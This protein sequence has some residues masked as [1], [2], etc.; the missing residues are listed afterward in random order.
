MSKI[1]DHVIRIDSSKV[2][3]HIAARLIANYV[4]CGG[5]G[6]WLAWI[7]PLWDSPIFDCYW[8]SETDATGNLASFSLV[9][10]MLRR[11]PIEQLAAFHPYPV[12]RLLQRHTSREQ[13]QIYQLLRIE[14]GYTIKLPDIC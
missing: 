2:R 6:K 12:L 3:V 9:E 5:H 13:F 8:K 14:Y 4:S 10:E 11:W 1:S 7:Q